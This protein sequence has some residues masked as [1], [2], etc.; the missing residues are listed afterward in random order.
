[1]PTGSQFL[2]VMIFLVITRD[3]PD[4]GSGPRP[5]MK[6]GRTSTKFGNFSNDFQKNLHRS[7]SPV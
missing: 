6:S 4:S 1:M 3:E 2:H 7:P 5:D